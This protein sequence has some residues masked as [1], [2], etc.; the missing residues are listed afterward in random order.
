MPVEPRR[1]GQAGVLHYFMDSLHGYVAF[2]IL[3][4]FA[5]VAAGFS[6]SGLSLRE[7]FSPVALG[8]A[9][10]LFVGKQVGVFGAAALAIGLKLARRP[11]GA[12]WIELAGV[13][14]LC[15]VGFTMSLF[16]GALAFRPDDVAAQTEVR[17]GV[18]AGSLLSTL[19]GMA[20]LGWSQARR[21]E[22]G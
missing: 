18:I 6:L 21:S 16:I 14:L 17:L 4:L 13:A 3:P 5:F 7:L 9:L 20:L 11:T 15:G 12:R 1:P 8:V 19:V 10:G 22:Q 2:L